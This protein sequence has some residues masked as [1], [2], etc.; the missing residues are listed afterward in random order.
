MKA[1]FNVDTL[2][3]DDDDVDDDHGHQQQ[4]YD[5]IVLVQLPDAPCGSQLDAPAHLFITRQALV[6]LVGEGGGPRG[7][8]EL[9]NI[10][11]ELMLV[12]L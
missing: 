11:P 8:D 6:H 10:C 3:E 7:S 9:W 5:E 1:W 4:E 2:D 12:N